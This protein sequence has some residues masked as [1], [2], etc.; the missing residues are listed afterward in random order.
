MPQRCTLK[1][2]GANLKTP[3]KAAG[4]PFFLGVRVSTRAGSGQDERGLWEVLRAR[5]GPPAGQDLSRMIRSHASFSLL[6]SRTLFPRVE[7]G[8]RPRLSP[9]NVRE[10]PPS[11]SGTHPQWRRDCPTAAGAPS[12]SLCGSAPL[13]RPVLTRREAEAA[14]SLH[15]LTRTRRGAPPF[16]RAS[17]PRRLAPPP[18]TPARPRTR[19]NVRGGAKREALGKAGR[20]LIR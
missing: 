17:H 13:S 18:G 12:P 11:G 7:G 2:T 14:R 16:T 10:L 8:A 5:R 3:C 15:L 19:T 9:H 4:T 6:K 1:A 20:S